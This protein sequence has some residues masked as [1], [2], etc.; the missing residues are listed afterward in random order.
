M[1]R[2]T[3]LLRAPAAILSICLL[4]L[5]A[6][7]VA[8]APPATAAAPTVK[9]MTFF[10]HYVNATETSKTLPGADSTWTYFDTTTEW[11]DVN[12]T[13]PVNGS[14]LVF[15][16]S[17]VPVLPGPVTV[18]GYSFAFWAES[19]SGN[20]NAQ[21]TLELVEINATG[22]QSVETVNFGSQSHTVSPSLKQLNATLVSPHT[23]AAGSS[24]QFVLTLNPGSGSML[25]IFD[26]ARADSRVVLRTADALA[27]ASIDVQDS[28]G[29]SVASLDPQ[30][31][32]RTARFVATVDDPYGGYDVVRANITILSPTG[33]VLV[34][35]ASM[36]RTGGTP[37]SRATTFAFGWNY[38]G[39]PPGEYQAIVHSMDNNG[40][41]WFTHFAQFSTGPYG[42]WSARSFFIGSLPLYAWV[43]V[44][45]D[46]DVAL[47]GAALEVLD[48]GT[49]VA[50]GTT[51]ALGLANLTA[52]AGNYTLAVG[53]A[54]VEVS[55]SSL[56]LTGNVTQGSPIV[57]HA[58]VYYPALK[59][60]DGR[61]AA[62]EYAFVYLTY[63]NGTVTAVPFRTDESGAVALAQVTGGVHA[64][65][66]LWRG[67]EVAGGP[68]T[69]SAS[70][71]VSVGAAVFYLS[72]QVNDAA[73][74]P[75][76]LALVR[77]DDAV[78]GLLSASNVT[79]ASGRFTERLPRGT[80]DATASWRGL[81]VGEVAGT[82]LDADKTVTISARVFAL[83][84]KA[85]KAD[86]APIAGATVTVLT[87]TGTVY[88][89]QVTNA[90]GTATFRMPGGTYNVAGHF[91][92]TTYWSPVEQSV[93]VANVT[94]DQG[95][96]VEL[97]FDQVPG[98]FVGSNMFLAL[99]MAALLV[100]LLLLV[101]RRM[102][103]I[104]GR[105][106]QP[107]EGASAEAKPGETQQPPTT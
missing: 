98:S 90:D 22:P 62:V 30:A 21:T 55:R 11:N 93:G 8:A 9:D 15:D 31:A 20:P 14:A 91:A 49:A 103:K 10:M 52:F 57:V 40:V 24:V 43:K 46:R 85:V 12:V 92:T 44:V 75:V 63:A 88:E 41:N 78:F 68:I 104:E 71:D 101:V 29:A 54:G 4:V 28:A 16:W 32:N 67:V 47:S 84:V 74:A 51:D 53:W 66:V 56:N 26:T 37:I 34:D 65:R 50:S 39:Q 45:D 1:P 35:N 70:A 106:G 23:F 59:V 100:A 64:A 48:G 82:V 73:G 7:L 79:S 25:I 5:G 80:Y 96:T 87:A 19:I 81:A 36:A 69:V 3:S 42:D 102:R 33:A 61:G 95:K 77:L 94:L 38:S 105:P 76:E 2:T 97:K 18:T 58:A 83:T 13:F 99:L 60:V 72:V 89:V 6:F 17:L 86:G 107:G 27:V